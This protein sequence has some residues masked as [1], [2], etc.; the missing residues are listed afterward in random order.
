MKTNVLNINPPVDTSP[1]EPVPFHPQSIISAVPT[2]E[3]S[4]ADSVNSF[5]VE[6][7]VGDS[8]NKTSNVTIRIK[9][10]QPFTPGQSV[11]LTGRNALTDTTFLFI[12]GP[13]IPRDGGKLTDPV[14]PVI[15]GQPASFDQA[16]VN[17]DCIW[18]YKWNIPT[19]MGWNETYSI[20]AEN[21]P[22]NLSNISE[23]TH[24]EYS[25]QNIESSVQLL[26]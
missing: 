2:N 3:L 17:D 9:G 21:V 16:L 22:N 25:Q 6:E 10:E 1:S 11:E 23:F 24:P 15:G 19:S 18:T 20:Y 4:H 13:A 14:S 26:D 8:S 5:S 7:T 12:T